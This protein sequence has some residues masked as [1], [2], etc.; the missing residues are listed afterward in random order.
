MQ[1]ILVTAADLA[2]EALA[3]LTSFEVI[4]AGKT[5]TAADVTALCKLHNPIAIIVRYGRIDAPQMDAAP[6]LKVISKHGS[7]IDTI[8]GVAA[9][10]RG[11]T[12]V[13]ATAVNADAVA[14]HS[15]ALMLAAAKSV[16]GLN[17]RMHGGHW[18]K[19]THKSLELRGKTVGL[20]GLGAIGLRFAM[21]CKALGMRVLGHD[22]Y[23]HTNPA[24]PE[25]CKAAG[26]EVVDL[27]TVLQGAD[28]LSLHCPLTPDNKGFINN[29]TL[30]QCKRGV[31]FINTARGG[32]VDEAAML[33]AVQSGQVGTAALDSFAVEPFS[34]PHPFQ[35]QAGFIL[36]PHI[37]GVTS[38]AYINMGVAA[39]QNVLHILKGSS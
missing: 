11:I 12:V 24:N 14:E 15:L 38:D 6:A 39:A 17:E 4:F 23:I 22:P 31:I 29:Q 21:L 2:K 37:G 32:L 13:A 10:E 16:I 30:A 9:K 25:R 19:A 18:D 1:K 33:T 8:D 27:A 5:P 34:A 7:G 3:L 26:V 28:V 35:N 36:S 20:V